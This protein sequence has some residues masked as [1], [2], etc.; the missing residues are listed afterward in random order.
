VKRRALLILPLAAFSGLDASFAAAGD[1]ERPRAAWEPTLLERFRF[2]AGA[3]LFAPAGVGSDGTICVGTADGYVHLLAPDGSFRWSHSVNG[4]VARRPVSSGG[5]WFIATSVGRIYALTPE[6]TLYW[7]F[8]PPSSVA[9]ELAADAT[10]VTYF[11]GADRFLYGVTVHGGVSLRTAF[12]QW[13]AGP[14]TAPDGAVWAENQA[15]ASIRVRGQELRR[16]APEQ[17]PEFDFGSVD[18]LRDP[19]GH[20]WRVRGDGVLAFKRNGAA[21][22]SLLDLT[23]V[24]LLLP[25][26]SPAT[27]CAVISARD[28]LVVALETTSPR[29]G[30]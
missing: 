23:S 10:G 12:G 8:K 2:H 18:V 15:G 25:S 20:E 5:L 17:R 7:V 27:R 4:A 16:M 19:D 26:W 9:S 11:L 21:E 6:G 13:K 1:E 3:A 30:P 22:P 29:Q 14:S 24:P 28:G